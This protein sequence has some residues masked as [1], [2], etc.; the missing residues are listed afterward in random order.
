VKISGESTQTSLLSLPSV[1]IP[2]F[3]G[4]CHGLK[5]HKRWVVPTS[6]FPSLLPFLSMDRKSQSYSFQHFLKSGQIVEASATLAALA[7]CLKWK[8][9]NFTNIV[10]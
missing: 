6:F 1:F 7:S 10:S 2:I 9:G 8:K 5:A 3:P 4:E